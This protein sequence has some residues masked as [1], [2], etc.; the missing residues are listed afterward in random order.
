MCCTGKQSWD[1][2]H[3]EFTRPTSTQDSLRRDEERESLNGL[4]R[5]LGEN[6]A[7]RDVHASHTGRADGRA[8]A[9][10]GLSCGCL[11][12]MLATGQ[13]RSPAPW[14]QRRRLAMGAWG[15]EAEHRVEEDLRG[16]EQGRTSQGHRAL[17]LK[18]LTRHLQAEGWFSL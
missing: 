3:H 9:S 7:G 18:V 12:T 8:Q 5:P 17:G 2:A 11:Q 6:S 1:L 16:W 15:E 13:Q 4:Q 10:S 14:H